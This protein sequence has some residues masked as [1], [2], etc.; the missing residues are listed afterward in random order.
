MNKV[1]LFYSKKYFFTV[2][3]YFLAVNKRL[4]LKSIS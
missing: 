4:N 2:K 1:D 3:K